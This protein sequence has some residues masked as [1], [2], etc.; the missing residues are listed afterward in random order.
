MLLGHKR[1]DTT[2]IGATIRPAQL[3]RE[4]GFYEEKAWRMLSGHRCLSSVHHGD[5]A[6][7]EPRPLGHAQ[8]AEGS[9]D[10]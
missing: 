4:M 8:G 9:G 1:I 2:Q 10:T 5:A 6:R 3:K 7:R